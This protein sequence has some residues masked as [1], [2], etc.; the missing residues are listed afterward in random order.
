MGNEMEVTLTAMAHGGAALAH[1][2]GGRIIFVPLAIP[3]ETVRVALDPKRSATII[4]PEAFESEATLDEVAL[5][6]ACDIGV[7]N[8][9]ACASARVAL[10]MSAAPATAEITAAPAPTAATRATLPVSMPP[11]ATRGS[12]ATS[13]TAAASAGTP[14]GCH[15]ESLLAVPKTGPKAT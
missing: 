1:A 3:G 11:I 4:G 12:G 10:R 7:A 8:Q 5:R 13:C 9:E 14:R 2:K 15:G 6:A